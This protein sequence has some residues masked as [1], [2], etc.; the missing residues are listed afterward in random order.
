MMPQKAKSNKKSKPMLILLGVLL[1]LLVVGIIIYATY[2]HSDKTE[3]LQQS[4]STNNSNLHLDESCS[5]L[6]S[7]EKPKAYI[8]TLSE[9]PDLPPHF[10]LSNAYMQKWMGLPR[11]FSSTNA[12][13][14]L[15]SNYDSVIR[16]SISTLTK[17]SQTNGGIF[18]NNDAPTLACS[19]E[20]QSVFEC[21]GNM[22]SRKGNQKWEVNRVA[23]PLMT[24]ARVT[25]STI[26]KNG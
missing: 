17:V 12:L 2:H 9:S 26:A 22:C 21:N 25:N 1:L 15:T 6:H 16:P 24:S 14:L 8:K 10:D 13:K 11:T 18:Q 23:I 19:S 20:N 4:K 7:S 5:S 3:T